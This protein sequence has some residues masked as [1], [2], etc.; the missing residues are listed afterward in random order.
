M[1]G[2]SREDWHRWGERFG[3]ILDAADEYD[4]DFAYVEPDTGRR[5]FVGIPNAVRAAID[6]RIATERTAACEQLRVA[7]MLRTRSTHA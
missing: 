1:T 4:A 3:W 2:Y 5:C 7:H 6:S